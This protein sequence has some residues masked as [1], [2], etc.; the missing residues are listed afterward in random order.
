MFATANPMINL[1]IK[2]HEKNNFNVICSDDC[3]AF[4]R[5]TNNR[6]NK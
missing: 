5:A 3:N 1:K 4:I 2:S 6:Y